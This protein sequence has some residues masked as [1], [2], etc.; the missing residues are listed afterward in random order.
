M[1]NDTLREIARE[2]GLND[3]AE[4]GTWTHGEYMSV[5][6]TDQW[7]KRMSEATDNLKKNDPTW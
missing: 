3:L 6:K 7:Q 5:V 1:V 2:A 4:K